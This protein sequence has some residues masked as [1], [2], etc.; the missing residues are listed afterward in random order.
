MGK[1]M[2]VITGRVT[3]PG[4]TITALTPNTGNT[5]T[6]R[7]FPAES[8]AWLEGL[9][10]QQATAGVVRVR[11]AKMHDNVQGI[12]YRSAAAVI[13]DLLSDFSQT[14]MYPTDTLSFEQS[15]GGA[16]TDAAA[17][18]LYYE[19][20]DGADQ[21]LVSYD[22]IRNSIVD[23]TTIEVA[24][25]GPTTTGDWAAGNA[26]NTT[27]DLLK[28]DTK[29]AILGY[30]CDTESLAV[31]IVGPDVSNL[32]V[33]GPGCIEPLET[34]DWF[35]R[36]SYDTGRPHIPVI[37]SNNRGGTLVTVAKVGAGGTVNVCLSVAELAG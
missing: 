35:V 19:N 13:R 7:A 31:G 8:M 33:G 27:F 25:T 28:A 22:Q 1:A 11:S 16:E 18:M 37:N 3:N 6:V 29:Y 2:E 26:L 17:M 23:L 24:V 12:R 30:Q 21:R 4:A 32:R 36:Q 15:G 9:W 10:A 34:R 20:L 14:R 5:F